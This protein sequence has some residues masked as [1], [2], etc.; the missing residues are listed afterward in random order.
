MTRRRIGVGV[1]FAALL[2][3]GMGS[4]WAEEGEGGP[5]DAGPRRLRRPARPGQE[6]GLRPRR[7]GRRGPRGPL[8]VEL[9]ALKEEMERHREALRGIL[10]GQRQVGETLREQ[11]RKLVQEGAEREEIKALIKEKGAEKAKEIGAKLAVELATHHQNLAKLYEEKKD[12]IAALI[13]DGIIKR[14]AAMATA[15]R[16]RRPGRLGPPGGGPGEEGGP[17]RPRREPPDAPDNF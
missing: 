4:A 8:G 11:L 17:R 15:R 5:G 9:P 3:S 1:L 7:E 10:S 2:A 13:A 6:P 16:G 12:E 14:V